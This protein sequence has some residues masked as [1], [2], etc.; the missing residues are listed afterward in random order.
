MKGFVQ[1]TRA[2]GEGHSNPYAEIRDVLT[3]QLVF[4]CCCELPWSYSLGEC[5]GVDIEGCDIKRKTADLVSKDREG[6][7]R[8]GMRYG[9]SLHDGIKGRRASRD[10]VR[11]DVEHFTKR[12]GGS[13][14]EECP[15][16][17]FSE[18]L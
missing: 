2:K 4:W 5:L 13:I 16:F 15:H 8:T 9:L 6:C 3:R 14:P 1:G 11:L 18:T 12:I 7:R 17:H 10:V